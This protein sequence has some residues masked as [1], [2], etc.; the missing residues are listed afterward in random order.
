VLISPDPV[1]RG[2]WAAGWR[3]RDGETRPIESESVEHARRALDPNTGGT[4][5]VVVDMDQDANREWPAAG[6]AGLAA[7]VS[8]TVRPV[9]VGAPVFDQVRSTLCAG[10]RGYLFRPP[11][12]KPRARRR[13]DRAP[14]RTA[15][16]RV[17]RTP[18]PP[19]TPAP[20]PAASSPTG[21]VAVTAAD[22]R[23]TFLSRREVD[24]LQGVAAGATNPEIASELGLSA[25][26]VKSHL[27]RINHRLRTVDRAHAVLLALRAGAIR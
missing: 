18:P 25:L 14:D 16:S 17:G 12:P 19:A 9:A 15:T 11:A 13:R 23:P 2:A 21:G 27:A 4:I 26:T 10:A 6:V 22:G 20:V 8:G 5:V 7:D 24:V 1:R 3:S